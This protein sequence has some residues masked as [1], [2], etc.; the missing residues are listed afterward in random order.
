ML[1]RKLFPVSMCII[2]LPTFSSI[3]FNVTGFN[4][5]SFICMDL[6]FVQDNRKVSICIFLQPNIQLCQNHLL[7]MLSF[8][9]LYHFD[10][11]V[12]NQ[13]FIYVWIYVRIFYLI[14]LSICL[15]F[16]QSHAVFNTIALA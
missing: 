15:F 8:F 5:R 16:C 3:R 2:L 12:K 4:L 7:K 11:L 6:S 10:F 14:Q 9:L 13:V 1:F